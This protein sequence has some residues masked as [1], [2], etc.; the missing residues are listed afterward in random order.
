[1]RR[2]QDGA[3]ISVAE[4]FPLSRA[5]REGD[6]VV[7]TVEDEI[8]RLVIG[9]AT[10]AIGEASL[11]DDTDLFSAGMTSYASVTMMMSIEEH[12]GVVFTDSQIIRTTFQTIASMAE[13][14]TWLLAQPSIP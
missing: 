11:T 2:N 3:G 8:R 4:L 5:R 14:V 10:L 7:P 1:M 12:F 13:A 6:G 9:N